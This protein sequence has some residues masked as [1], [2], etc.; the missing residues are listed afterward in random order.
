[1]YVCTHSLTGT[2]RPEER[3]DGDK[4]HNPFSML[5]V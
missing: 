2:Q 5:S 3:T 1:M 4:N